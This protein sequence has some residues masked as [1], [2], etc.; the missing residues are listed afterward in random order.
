VYYT[1]RHG[2]KTDIHSMGSALFWVSA[3][4]TTVSSQ[5]ANPVTTLGRVIDI[6]LE[7][8]AITVV[9]ALVGSF[10]SFF[11][12]RSIERFGLP[13]PPQASSD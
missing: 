5:M 4:L 9:M 10:A 3:Q 2:P 12:R 13:R 7:I 11:H 1:E 6:A 8:Y